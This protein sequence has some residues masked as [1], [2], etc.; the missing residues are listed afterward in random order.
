MIAIFLRLGVGLLNGLGLAGNV[1]IVPR[2][3]SYASGASDLDRQLLAPWFILVFLTQMANLVLVVRRW[4]P[5]RVRRLRALALALNLMVFVSAF[6]WFRLVPDPTQLH[7]P[8]CWAF[9]SVVIAASGF[10]ALR[11]TK[12]S[13]RPA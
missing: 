8:G 1:A 2:I 9:Y 6:L 4:E 11:L 12:P 10:L 13:P 3:W 7:N 5:S